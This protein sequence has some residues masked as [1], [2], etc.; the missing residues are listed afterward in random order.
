VSPAV[1]AD[2]APPQPPLRDLL[3]EVPRA[4]VDWWRSLALAPWLRRVP[5]GDG[6]PVIVLPGFMAS[7]RSTVLLRSF[8]SSLGYATYGWQLGRNIGPTDEV[9]D[10]LPST[11]AR[12]AET[13]GRRVS[14]IGWSL[15]GIMARRL[16][17]EQPDP[18]RQV[19]TLGSPIGMR[20]KQQ[21]RASA[22]YAEYSSRHSERYT[23][24]D[25][26]VPDV[27]PLPVPSTAIY[28]RNDGIV[29]WTTCTQ[30]TGERSENIEV[31]GAHCG[32]GHHPA[33]LLAIGDRLAQPEGRW[34]AFRPPARVRHWYPDPVAA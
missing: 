7:D 21:S 25:A 9:V 17:R 30:V 3:L 26:Y 15:G 20:D 13:H 2:T 19:I 27:D 31:R 32:L 14:L 5:E 10:R 4:S 23:L 29:A 18:V 33:A 12:L 11:I 6:H 16:C 24:D 8:V 22:R 34:R 1:P 28:T